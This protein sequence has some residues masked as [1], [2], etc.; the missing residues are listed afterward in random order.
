[1]IFCDFDIRKQKGDALAEGSIKRAINQVFQDHIL[2][3]T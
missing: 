1:M 2:G 3:I